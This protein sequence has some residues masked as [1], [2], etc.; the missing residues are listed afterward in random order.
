MLRDRPD[1]RAR[2]PLAMSQ[3]QSPDSPNGF[4]S[5]EEDRE[6]L[7]ATVEEDAYLDRLAEIGS[8]EPPSDAL[9]ALLQLGTEW[10][11]IEHA[12]LA[13]IDLADGTHTIED[14]SK[15][16]PTVSQGDTRDLSRTFCR[17]VLA[18]NA[19][20]AIEDAT[21]EG[22]DTDPAYEEFGV[23]TYVGAKVVA[24]SEFY[25]TLCFVDRE[26]RTDPLSE[27]ET[28]A[29]GL[30]VRTA[31]RLL[32][33]DRSAE[34]SPPT[35][36]QLEALF[37]QS[38]NMINV[39]DVEGTLIAPN[40]HLCEKTG[41]TEDELTGMKV[42]ELDQ[43][44]TPDDA[45]AFWSD[46]EPGDRSRWEGTYQR[47]DGTTFPVEVDLRRL[48][49][50]GDAR[51]IA[52]GRDIT[53]RREA[54]KARQ[55]SEELHRET[56][57][58]IT[59][60][61]FLTRDDGTF[62]YVC[63]NV[64]HIFGYDQQ[65]AEALG[66]ISALLGGDPFD[67][68][69]FNG[70]Q[71]ITNVEWSI[72]DADG[73]L[74]DLLINIRKVSIRDGTRMYTCRDV[75][76]RKER[77]RQLDAVFNQTYQFTGLLDPDGTLVK[78]NDTALQFGGL[79]EEDVIG[80]P[81]WETDW[82]QTGSETKDRLRASVQRAADGEFVRYEET[83]QGAEETRIIDF[84]LRPVVGEDGTVEH[85]IPEGRDITERTEAA[86]ELRETKALLEKTFESLSEVVV[87]VDPSEREII[88][89]NAAVEE[90]FGYERE[91][92]IGESTQKLHKNPEA[93]ERFAA[94]GEPIL[95][96]EGLFR[97]E[98]QMQRKD[99]QLIETEHVVTPL[100]DE[101]W[102]G[103][104]VSIIRDIT[105]RKRTERALQEE[106]DLL[107]RILETSPAA[108]A[109]LNTE[110]DFVEAS[111]RAEAV[112][113][114]ERD[115]VEGRTYND[116]AWDICGPEGG[117]MPDEELPFARVMATE[118]P[119]YDVE[120]RIAWPDGTQRL[121]SVSGAPLHD[122]DGELEGAVF[123]LDD[124]TEQ[125]AARQA[126]REERDRFAT[127]FHNLPTPVVHG[128]PDSEGRI[129]VEAANERFEAVFGYEE[130][131]I[132]GDDLQGLIVP[133][134]EKD[135][136]ESMRQRLLAGT[137]VNRVVRRRTAD[138]L[139][140]FRVQ[141]ALREGE[142]DPTEGFA[143]YTDITERRERERTLARRK[144]V[145]EAQAES[146]ID[147]LL[148]VDTDRQVLFYN[149]QFLE[150][151]D[152]PDTLVDE[153]HD[154]PFNQILLEAASDLLPNPDSFREKI[155]YL[156]DHPSEESRDLIDLTDGRCL[157]R[158]SAPIVGDEG[159]R[160]GR[161]WVFRDVT[162]QRRML[163][164]LLE[165]QEEERRRID[166]EIHDEMG[167]LLTSLQLTVD[168]ARRAAD[169]D[170]ASTE[171][172]DQLEDLVSELSTV[173]RTISRKLY[174]SDLPEYGLADA[175]SS[176]AAEVERERGL[177]VDLYSE[178]EPD[179]RFPALI[180]RTAYWIVQEALIN[181][182]RHGE[183][184]AAQVIVS[185]RANQLY[186]HVFDEQAAFL[187][188]APSAE[189]SFRLEVIQRRVEW[190]DGEVRIDAIPGEGTRFSVILPVR[191]PF[192][193]K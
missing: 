44:V 85:I 3:A 42:W 37:A 26:A 126:L 13:R 130:P 98:Y 68:H 159:S 97:H 135:A 147:G 35:P 174:P 65:A 125:R 103:G 155:E 94:I 108:I 92:L 138:G 120:H 109:V 16:H 139:R 122:P 53:E 113:G 173:S 133:D 111:G 190:L 75:T 30:L 116:P 115:E 62:T 154:V 143:I 175:F 102:P 78:A 7:E 58:N 127:L 60:A 84:S 99:G 124:I 104:V 54:E 63:P 134:E 59:D 169:P 153:E 5:V 177:E 80:Q 79:E 170:E 14:V 148:A 52:T 86:Q 171:H 17:R 51:F 34:Q 164:R 8:A 129:R 90:V 189:K 10:L 4:F 110:G 91:E 48:D 112:L 178:M 89:C 123:H 23:S 100:Q 144:A 165:V 9:H 161:L 136:S 131:A 29:L 87:V 157:D 19:A 31:G 150:I 188:S 193:E 43:D 83:V 172:F 114:L 28:A 119:V 61:V 45:R 121:L 15:P 162:Q 56:L 77:E 81:V 145:L 69:D 36:S 128:R 142:S 160:F 117:P 141:V 95:E 40:P 185:K 96:E 67:E 82:F 55:R 167:G 25:G 22:W 187:P 163:E 47:K 12:H 38:P 140:D 192:P 21:E 105:E 71:E 151:W 158:Y 101:N 166:Q 137:P 74:H 24:G 49:G 1:T 73:H 72:T 152:I 132:R 118:A 76:E 6:T 33:D 106:R 176:L 88:A 2:F 179:D 11:D 18:N 27:A 70:E 93:Y 184:N 191:L 168:L 180:E 20:L 182:A 57:R 66:S 156:Y 149:E 183:T 32:A 41:Y 46:L 39:H 64:S 186:L 181:V 50:E 107:N 146:T